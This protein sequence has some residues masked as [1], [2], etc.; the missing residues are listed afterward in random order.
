MHRTTRML[1]AGLILMSAAC[2][3]RGTSADSNQ[4]L[5]VAV[6]V[7]NHYALQVDVYAVAGGTSYLMGTVSP[8]IDSRYVLRQSLLALGPVQLVARPRGGEQPF[9]SQQLL[10]APGDVVE[11]EITSTLINSTVTVRQP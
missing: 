9:R 7:I 6:H 1:I 8:G 4:P 2:A 5:P 3:H 10:L 11:L